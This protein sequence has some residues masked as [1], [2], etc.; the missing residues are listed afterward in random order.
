[1][2]KGG[3]PGFSFLVCPDSALLLQ[4]AD[5]LLALPGPDG[6]GWKRRVFW[7]DEPPGSKF[8][9]SLKQRGLFAANTAVIVRKA[10]EWPARVWKS[11]DEALAAGSASVWPIFCLECEFDRKFKIPP[12]IEKSKAYLFAS[13]S[14][15]VWE[16]RPLEGAELRK[17]AISEAEKRKLVLD[18]EALDSFCGLVPASAA[19]VA[20]A[21]DQL[22]LAHDGGEIKGPLT[23]FGGAAPE[24]NAFLCIKSLYSGNTAQAWREALQGDASSLLFF[25]IALLAKDFHDFWLFLSG[26][27][28]YMHY[29]DAALKQSLSR[30]LG[31][32][33]LSLAFAM[34]AEAEYQVKSGRLAPEQALDQLLAGL[35]R[36]FA[37]K[38]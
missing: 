2:E 33:G 17:F 6:G 20:N 13:K 34:L 26:E 12:H 28:P 29:S 19:A 11:L 37:G 31:R 5:S 1:M 7:G 30:R 36:L 10:Q 35:G 15:W 9:E 38:D 18:Q 4:K 14:R 21:L 3:R 23:G 32:K 22:A 25:L 27:N 16:R 8:W 24:A